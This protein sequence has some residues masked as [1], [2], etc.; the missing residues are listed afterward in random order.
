MIFGFVLAPP[1]E[2]KSLLGVYR[3]KIP[4]LRPLEVLWN[5]TYQEAYR[6][7]LESGEIDT[8]A[9]FWSWNPIWDK[10]WHYGPYVLTLPDIYTVHSEVKLELALSQQF[11]P[12]H[13]RS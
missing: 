4:G 5:E 11:H 2:T 1:P 10:I 8:T 12:C 6:R 9:D 13:C 3:M 7:A